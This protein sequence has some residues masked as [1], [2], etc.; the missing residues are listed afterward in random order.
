MTEITL[1]LSDSMRKIVCSAFP[2]AQR[3]IDRF[4]IQ[5][6]AC[7]AVQ[8][9]RIKHRWEAMQEAN[10]DME[11][12]KLEGR[13]YIPI[14]YENRDTKKELLARSRYLLF[15]SADRWTNNQNKR[16]KILFELYTKLKKAYSLSHSLRMIFAK[17][18]FKDADRLSMAKW[19]NKVEEAGFHSFN[20]IAATFYEHYEDILNFYNNRSS[21]AAAESFNAKVKAFRTALRGIR[22]EKFF[23]Y[24]LALIYAYLH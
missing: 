17:N 8:E 4:H 12:V 20:V 2:K 5:K 1:D 13:D 15:K 18:T 6:L 19:Y 11:N 14:R 10:D 3:V 9:M 16:A 24:R 22:D 21:N 7:D 23:L